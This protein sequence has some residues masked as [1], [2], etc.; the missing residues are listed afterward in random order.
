MGT[1]SY[2]NNQ[3]YSKGKR[4]VQRITE[5]PLYTDA[6]RIIGEINNQQFPYALLNPIVDYQQAAVLPRIVLRIFDYIDYEEDSKNAAKIAL[7][8]STKSNFETYTSLGLA[9]EISVLISL[10]LGIRLKPGKKNRSFAP[11]SKNKFGSILNLGSHENP[12]PNRVFYSV[13]KIPNAIRYKSK[14]KAVFLG[15]TQEYLS[16]LIKIKDKNNYAALIRSAKL[17]SNALWICETDPDNAW[18]LLVSAIETASNAWKK[19]KYDK[20]KLFREHHKELAKLLDDSCSNKLIIKKIAEKLYSP[21]QKKFIDFIKTFHKKPKNTSLKSGKINWNEYESI[22][23]QIY[24][25]RSLT[26][27]TGQPFP[28]EMSEHP[29][30]KNKMLEKPISGLTFIGETIITPKDQPI[31]LWRFEDIVRKSLLKWLL[32]LE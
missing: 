13:P 18:L 10:I 11:K 15:K 20:I 3:K 24:N 21:A 9:E 25:L 17:Y 16:H 22:L 27:H 14:E 12:A 2:R 7:S 5:Y 19:E 6:Q 8:K 4:K 1:I 28:P 31:L 26:L 29:F 23:K 30:L 32:S